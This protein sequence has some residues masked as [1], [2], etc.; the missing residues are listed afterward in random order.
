MFSQVSVH[1]GGGGRGGGAGVSLLVPCPFHG[2]MGISG[3]RS[4][5][6]DEVGM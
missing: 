1:W 4:L 3:T 2:G 6:G 5:P